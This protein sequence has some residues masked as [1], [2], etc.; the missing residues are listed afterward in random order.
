M[1]M[2]LCGC[3]P[4]LPDQ[5]EEATWQL[6]PDYFSPNN[7]GA[8]LPPN[9]APLNFRIM[10]GDASKAVSRIHSAKGGEIIVGGWDVNIDEEDWHHLLDK[11]R[12]DTLFCDIYL[13]AYGKWE[14]LPTQ[15]FLIAEEPIDPYITYRLIRPS[16]VT[17][18][19]LTINE[20]C[21]ENFD[22]RVVYE[23]M[24]FE[25]SDQG[26]CINCH[27]PRDW[28]RQKES[29]F[30]VRQALG[31]TVFIHGDQVTKVNLKTDSTLSAGV[32]PAWHPTLNL[33]AYSV[34]ETGQVFHTLDPQKVEVIDYASDLILY[35]LDSNTVQHIDHTASEFES[36]PTWSPDGR[37]LYYISA[38]YTPRAENI[39]A[40]LDANYDQL[41]YNLFARDFDLQ[42]HRF[43][44]RR[45]VFDAEAIDKSA[46]QP[47]VSPDGQY[48]LFTLA[49]YGQ[50]HIW[51]K[52]AELWLL[53]LNSL[54]PDLSSLTPDPSPNGEGSSYFFSCILAP[55][56]IT[57]LSIRRGVGGEAAPL[58]TGVGGE[59]GADSY[60]SWSSNGRWILFSSR[61]DDGN[62]TRLYISYFDKDGQ[63]HKPFR[64]PQ[65]SPDNDDLLLRSYNVAEFLLQPVQPTERQLRRAIK[66][67][68]HPA[69]YTGSALLHPE[70]DSTAVL[71]ARPAE[72]R[73]GESIAY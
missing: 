27:L 55:Q 22:E 8:T 67:D 12:G 11:T 47:R 43:G 5:Y 28:N 48:L 21:L 70:A 36:F 19:E 68:A 32:Y 26:Q 72:E 62:Y 9:V 38:H 20:R 63:V 35:D 46:S 24:R 15:H 4:S 6:P 17:Y 42:S 37:T 60:H 39:D 40:D 18:E 61:R 30:H 57:P 29:Q 64:L 3:S 51:H 45:L 33:I 53:R 16:Y 34:N 23:N 7:F 59:A 2:L 66:S 49:D 54:T 71:P 52:S 56:V 1:V 73:R 44:P 69:T 58:E 50:F 10:Q 65:R 41:H 25:D 31:G 13:K 14:H